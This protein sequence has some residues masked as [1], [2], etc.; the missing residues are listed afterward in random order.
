METGC[1]CGCNT[2]T[3]VTN[4]EEPCSCGCAC[5]TEEPKTK[6]DEIAE[7]RA[8]QASVRERLAELGEDV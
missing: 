4:A 1:G 5:C 6:E 7:L 8:L 2:L 3:R